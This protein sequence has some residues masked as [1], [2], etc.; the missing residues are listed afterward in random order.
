MR[1]HYDFSDGKKNPYAKRMKKGIHIRISEVALDYFKK[2]AEKEG[3]PYQTLMNSFLV[4]CATKKKQ[5]HVD[6]D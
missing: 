5:M 4:D 1:K 2:L 6:W 3:V